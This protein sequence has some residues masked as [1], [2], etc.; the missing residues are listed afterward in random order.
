VN[1]SESLAWHVL[2]LVIVDDLD[3]VSISAGPTET[4]SPLVV[5]ANAV[6]TYAL[7]E[8]FFEVVGGWDT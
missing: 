6:L 1:R 7:A 8:K 2:L 5:D 3:V 4:D